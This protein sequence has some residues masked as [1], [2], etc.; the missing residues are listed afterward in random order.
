[1]FPTVY[2]AKRSPGNVNQSARNITESVV[3]KFNLKIAPRAQSWLAFVPKPEADSVANVGKHPVRG[4][5]ALE[6]SRIACSL[7]TFD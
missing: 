7:D 6:R 3:G 5:A 4:A 1:M 2:Q